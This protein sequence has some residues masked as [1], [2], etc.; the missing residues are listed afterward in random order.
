MEVYNPWICIGHVHLIRCLL[1]D[2]AS[3]SCL[4]SLD[5]SHLGDWLCGPYIGAIYM[6]VLVCIA[7]MIGLRGWLRVLL[8]TLDIN[9]SHS[10]AYVCSAMAIDWGFISDVS[11][12]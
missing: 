12:R 10:R 9:V 1:P 3:S 7:F 4:S 6:L 2:Q 11:Y 5:I 8:E